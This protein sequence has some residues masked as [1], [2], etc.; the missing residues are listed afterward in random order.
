M[1]EL[2]VGLAAVLAFVFGWNNSSFLI[3]NLR[4]SGTLSYRTTAMISAAGLL[5][6]AL[7]EGPKMAG[8][9][10]GALSPSTS[11]TVLLST[12]IVTILLTLA[13]TLVGLPVSFSVVMVG[14]FLGGTVASG[15][16]VDA[17]RS[18]SVI[19]FW[20]VAP[21]IVAVFTF[22]IYSSIRRFVSRLGILAVD[23]LNRAG[24][25]FSALAVSYALGA[26]NIGLILGG[27]GGTSGQGVQEVLLTTLLIVSAAAGMLTLGRGS[28]SGTVGDR[29]LSLSP[30]GVFSAFVA[31]SLVVWI[32]TQLAIPVSISQCL[33]GGML[34]AAY[35]RSITVLNTR[36]TLQTVSIWVIAPLLSFVLSY[37]IILG[38]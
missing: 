30:Q 36:L 33:L 12:I 13:F 2:L 24:A 23:S 18:E 29:M 16:Q 14:G 7:F 38:F 37:A 19:L 25:A 35:T 28:V 31:S 32:G 26:N 5:V 1:D 27:T 10:V 15:L 34:G 17:V 3:G 11:V 6:G 20:F 21:F 8:S 4:G 22:V 9:L